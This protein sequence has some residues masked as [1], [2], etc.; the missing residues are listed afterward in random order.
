MDIIVLFTILC[1]YA[2][3]T[4]SLPQETHPCPSFFLKYK[5]RNA[6]PTRI[7]N[8]IAFFAIFVLSLVGAIGLTARAASGKGLCEDFA[9]KHP[10]NC[11]EAAVAMTFTW[12][13][14]VIGASSASLDLDLIC[15]TIH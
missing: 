7:L 1:L 13:S 6:E 9:S 5:R 2:A 4:D 11:V 12:A 14:V 3:S 10:G 8:L 15:L